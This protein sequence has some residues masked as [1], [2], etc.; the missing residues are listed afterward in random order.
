MLPDG[1]VDAYEGLLRGILGIG[2]HAHHTADMP[3]HGLHISSHQL[4]ES[5][6]GMLV[7]GQEYFFVVDIH[8]FYMLI[9]SW[10]HFCL[11]AITKTRRRGESKMRETK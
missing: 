8:G 4:P 2:M 5:F 10:A 11:V 7:Y 6:L 1:A 3:I 9:Q